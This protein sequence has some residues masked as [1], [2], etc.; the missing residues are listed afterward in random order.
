MKVTRFLVAF[1]FVCVSAFGIASETDVKLVGISFERFERPRYLSPELPRKGLSAV[2]ELKNGKVLK[3]PF[4]PGG[5]DSQWYSGVAA[6]EQF[7]LKDAKYFGIQESTPN[8]FPQFEKVTGVR[9]SAYTTGGERRVIELP[10]EVSRPKWTIRNGSK[11]LPA[12]DS[13]E[14]IVPWSEVTV[15]VQTADGLERGSWLVLQL[16]SKTGE[17]ADL[18]ADPVYDPNAFRD[19]TRT[20]LKR[21]VPFNFSAADTHRIR[22][23]LKGSQ[24]GINTDNI[25]IKS[26]KVESRSVR[27]AQETLYQS[28][29]G[30]FRLGL[31]EVCWWQS[32]MFNKREILGAIS[33][34][35]VFYEI[36]TGSDG[37]RVDG[38]EERTRSRINLIVRNRT[39][40][41]H[42][43]SLPTISQIRN[44]AHFG[45]NGTCMGSFILR[46]EITFNSVNF[47]SLT[48]DLGQ[49]SSG[50]L[51]TLGA[52]SWDFAG[53]RFLLIDGN[54]VKRVVYSNVF[55]TRLSRSSAQLASMAP[56]EQTTKLLSAPARHPQDGIPGIPIR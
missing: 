1:V 15:T 12:V 40:Q 33:A 55:N 31:K 2:V 38:S 36:Y 25:D 13:A 43:E 30:G 39:N 42:V 21:R 4:T 50:F 37:L 6:F 34:S 8:V 11:M 44:D 18:S 10:S 14:A 29:P 35:K 26:L 47:F 56:V 22:V 48:H 27:R 54:N 5:R 3:A 41:D 24:N 46:D 16:E 23:G 52:D 17:T 7:D 19:N 32:P 45:A 9:V 20:T 28:E 51:N 53:I 49:P